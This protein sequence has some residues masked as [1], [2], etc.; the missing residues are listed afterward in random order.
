MSRGWWQRAWQGI[1]RIAR[2]RPAVLLMSIG[3]LTLAVWVL[4]AVDLPLPWSPGVQL[5]LQRYDRQSGAAWLAVRSRAT[6]TAELYVDGAL[7]DRFPVMAGNP[8]TYALRREQHRLTLPDGPRTVRVEAIAYRSQGGVLSARP[9]TLTRARLE[10]A[11][12]SSAW[13]LPDWAGGAAGVTLF[14]SGAG[15]WLL[16]R[17]R[18]ADGRGRRNSWRNW[19]DW[20]R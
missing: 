14:A 5:W 9:L 8:A 2:G 7:V 1:A 4:T 3:A 12:T 6:G 10:A 17:V 15:I 18:A 11:A 16:E 20:T 13:G 19:P